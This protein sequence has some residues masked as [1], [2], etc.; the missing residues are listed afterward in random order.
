MIPTPNPPAIPVRNAFRAQGTSVICLAL[1]KL[2]E[3]IR[4]RC[5]RNENPTCNESKNIFPVGG[6]SLDGNVWTS[7]E[8]SGLSD[9]LVAET[10]LTRPSRHSGFLFLTARV[11]SPRKSSSRCLE[12]EMLEAALDCTLLSTATHHSPCHPVLRS[13]CRRRVEL[14]ESRSHHPWIPQAPM[15]H[16]PRLRHCLHASSLSCFLECSLVWLAGSATCYPIRYNNNSKIC[17][18]SA[19]KNTWHPP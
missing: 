12:L 15:P 11:T 10:A 6:G 17:Q 13:H 9:M 1:C 8:E 4:Q 2:N 16:L 14:S 18:V 5:S 7:G 19:R 3:Y